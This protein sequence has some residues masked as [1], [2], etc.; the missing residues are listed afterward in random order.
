MTLRGGLGVEHQVSVYR[1]ALQ[2]GPRSRYL[3]FYAQSNAK[4][5]IRAKLNVFLQQVHI[6]IQYLIHI[7][8]SVE[9][10]RNLGKI[11]LNEPG[12]QKLGR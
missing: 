11:N 1:C 5:H 3:V 12:R 4:G 2:R 7:S 6:L 10:W 9:G 8:P